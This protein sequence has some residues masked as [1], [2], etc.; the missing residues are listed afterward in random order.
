MRKKKRNDKNWDLG[1]DLDLK[2][3]WELPNLDE[4]E[5]GKL[6]WSILEARNN[7]GKKPRET[8]DKESS[9]HEKY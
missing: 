7:H 1:I 8:P 2:M 9:Q 6:A 4:E 3:N 5:K